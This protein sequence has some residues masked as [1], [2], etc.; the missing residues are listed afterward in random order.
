MRPD[1]SRYI[2]CMYFFWDFEFGVCGM[3]ILKVPVVSSMLLPP[4]LFLPH[5]EYKY[6]VELYTGCSYSYNL[7]HTYCTSE[8]IQSEAQRLDPAAV[9]ILIQFGSAGKLPENSCA[10]PKKLNIRNTK[11]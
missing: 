7:S 11:S 4:Y 10:P 1:S 5:I 3:V 6:S 2:T 9:G 8:V